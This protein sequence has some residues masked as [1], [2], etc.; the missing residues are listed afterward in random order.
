MTAA[1]VSGD[2]HAAALIRSLR[3]IRPDVI[4]EGLGGQA[5]RDAGATIHHDTVTRAA[6]GWRAIFRAMEF[7]RLLKWTDQHY[8]QNRIDLHICIDSSGV[9]F[10]FARLAR[11]HG[12]KVLYYIAPQVWASREGRIKTMQQCIDRI[13][14][15]WQFEEECFR[16]HGLQATY[17]GHPLFDELPPAAQRLVP[18]EQKYPERPPIVGLLPGSRRSD[19]TANLP[20]LLDVA[21]RIYRA[22]PDV[23]FY[24]PTTPATDPVVRERVARA[25]EASVPCPP[26]KRIR[27]ELDG[28]D[29]LVP[30][31]DLCVTKSGTS[32]LHVAAYGVPM[33]VVYRVNPIL[34]HGIGRW[35]VKTRTFSIVNMLADA[36]EH[37]V[38]EHVPWYGSNE[39]VANQ[40]INYLRRPDDLL[41]QRQRL[42]QLIRNIDQPGASENAA[43]VVMEMIG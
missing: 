41:A 25:G 40:A 16:R 9:N 23:T 19:A 11:R 24:I 28:F 37:I 32:T 22:V 15:I 12:A 8:A 13:A 30:H 2:Q 35:I 10:H 5:M 4:V 43:R 7:R 1:E 26:A 17:V 27:I 14:C 38:P 36:H 31:C 20:H 6:M 42:L 3:A 18:P 34:W 21:E 33:I 39:P 29:R